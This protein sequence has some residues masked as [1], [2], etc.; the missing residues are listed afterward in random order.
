[1]NSNDQLFRSVTPPKGFPEGVFSPEVFLELEMIDRSLEITETSVSAVC[2]F[3]DEV[4][5]HEFGRNVAELAT[6]RRADRLGRALTEEEVLTYAGY[7][8]FSYSYV[9]RAAWMYHTVSAYL[10]PE[11]GLDQHFR[12]AICWNCRPSTKK[13]RKHERQIIKSEIARQLWG[14]RR[15]AVTSHQDEEL[16]SMLPE[17]ARP[18]AA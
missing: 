18:T 1:M 4:D 14:P 2:A 5:V 17:L 10:H 12:L 6:A 13:E 8:M 11:P 16:A 7:Y 15:V 9:I 3:T